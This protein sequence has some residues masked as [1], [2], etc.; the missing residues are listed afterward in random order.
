MGGAASVGTP[1][2]T[3]A[4]LAVLHCWH[5][6]YRSYRC[7]IAKFMAVCIRCRGADLLVS[8]AP[9]TDTHS[10]LVAPDP[11]RPSLYPGWHDIIAD[12]AADFVFSWS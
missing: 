2:D 9:I 11:L 6:V 3:V 5:T 12:A 1:V 4:G 8:M 10:V 7:L